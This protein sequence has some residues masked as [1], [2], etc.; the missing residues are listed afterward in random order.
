MTLLE[1]WREIAYNTEMDQRQMNE[2]WNAYFV[3]E[4]AVYEDLLGNPDVKVSGTVKTPVPGMF[5]FG[6]Q[7]V[8]LKAGENAIR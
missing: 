4:K 7:V 6:D 5:R 1:Q 2:F 3:Q 8:S